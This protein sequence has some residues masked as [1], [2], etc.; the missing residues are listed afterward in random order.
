[1]KQLA[2]VVAGEELVD[3]DV[4]QPCAQRV[5]TGAAIGGGEDARVAA[6]DHQPA[7]LWVDQDRLEG[8]VGQART[9]VGP[10]GAAV[11]GLEDVVAS[12]SG[13]VGEGGVDGKCVGRIDGDAGEHA[14]GRA[15]NGPGG[16]A[17]ATVDGARELAAIQASVDHVAIGRRHRQRRDLAG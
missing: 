15:G 2:A 12:A 14:S 11:G 13:E 5:P 4:G 1:H 8:D 9:D 10:V 17:H 6:G 7:V 3:R 16:P